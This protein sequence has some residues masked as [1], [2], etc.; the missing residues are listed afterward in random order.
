MSSA[1][2]S[3]PS[4][5][6]GGGSNPLPIFD[7]D[8][9]VRKRKCLVLT[10]K[11]RLI[12]ELAQLFVAR[13]SLRAALVITTVLL[14]GGGCFALAQSVISTVGGG[15]T[16]AI[17][18]SLNACLPIF[19]ARPYGT[20]IY[21]VS[22]GRIYKIDSSGNWTA[23]AGTGEAGFS[24]DG[25]P[26]LSAKLGEPRSISLDNNGNI[27]FLDTLNIRVRKVDTSGNISTIAGTG[28]AGYSGDGG[29]AIK[30]QIAGG[31]GP[32]VFA[33]SLGN[34]YIADTAN[35]RVRKI[36][37]SLNI[38]T[39][40]GTGLRG[41][42][43]DNILATSAQLNGPLDVFVDGSG[44][45]F[46]GEAARVR[47]IDA[48]TKIIST[49]AGTGATG[50]NGD[51]I[52]ATTAELFQARGVFVDGTGNVFISDAFNNRVRKVSTG[53][54][55]STVAGNGTPYIG[56]D[57]GPAVNAAVSSPY[58]AILD[59]S[60]NL[61]ITEFFYGVRKV[62]A[63]TQQ[64]S[65]LIVNSAL[66]FTGV[67]GPAVSAQLYSPGGAVQD[68]AGNIFFA[69]QTNQVVQE[70]VKSEGTLV[71]VAGNGTSG[72]SGDTG[73]AITAQLSVPTAVAL[74]TNGDIFIADSGNNVIRRVNAATQKIT[75]VAGNGTQG[76][77]G[78]GPAT[79]SELYNP[80]G[81]FV[82][83]S[84]N[85]FI[86]DL[87]NAL[88]RRVDAV[89][90]DLSTVA[91]N[92]PNSGYGGNGGA[93]TSAILNSPNG[94]FVDGSGNL[95]IADAGNNI[96]QRVDAI[97]KNISTV[98]G[99][100]LE[101]PGF[102]G[103]GGPATSAQLN[104]PWAIWGDS[105]GNLFIADLINNRIREFTVGG[106]IQTVAGSGIQGFSG[107]GG[108]PVSA[109]LSDPNSVFVGPND[110]LVIVDSSN[111]HIRTVELGQTISFG[112][113]A[114]QYYVNPPFAISATASSGLP[115]I[116]NSQ[117]SSTCA[118]SGGTVT[119]LAVGTCTIQATQPGNTQYAAAPPIEQSF[120]VTQQNQ[121]V[122]GLPAVSG[123]GN[124][125][126]FGCPNQFNLTEFQQV[127]SSTTFPGPVT[128]NQITFFNTQGVQ[129]APITPANYQ[130]T[131]STTSEAI[132]GLDASN[133]ANN[134]GPDNQIF[135]SG[136]LSGPLAAQELTINGTPFAYDPSNGNLLLMIFISGASPDT[137]LA[138]DAAGIIPPVTERVYAPN[139][140]G[141]GGRSPGLVTQFSTTASAPQGPVLAFFPSS[142]TFSNL[143]LLA[144][145]PSYAVTLT[146]AGT[147]TL[148]IT[149]ISTTGDF[150]SPSNS[151]GGSISAG[152]SCTINVTFTPTALGLRT[153]SLLISDNA[154][155][156]PQ[157]VM[158]TSAV[159]IDTDGDGI[160][161]D[162]ETNG[163]TING[164]FL[165]LPAMGA[166][167]RHKDVFVQTDYMVLLPDC[168][169]NPCVPGHS[170]QLQADAMNTLIA[171]YAKAPVNNPDGTTGITL[172]ID[173]GPSCIMNPLTGATWGNRSLANSVP[174]LDPVTGDV[175][176][177]GA[178]G[179]SG[180]DWS[181]FNLIK[182]ANL[183]PT[184]A[185]VFHYGVF[186]HNLDPAEGGTS[187]LSRDNPASDFVVSLGS[188]TGGVGSTGEQ[189]GTTMHELGH[190]LGLTHGGAAQPDLSYKPNFTSVMNYLFQTRG[191][192]FDG[193]EGNF[194]YSRFALPTLNE[195]N[196]NEQLGLDGGA[197]FAGYGTAYFCNGVSNTTS[198]DK[199]V[200]N[201]NLPIDWNCD[202]SIESSVA[203][204]IYG[205]L[206]AIPLQKLTGFDDWMNLVFTGG[207][208]G[209]A[210]APPP[211]PAQT[212]A[213]ELNSAQDA[214]LTTIHGVGVVGPGNTSLPPGGNTTLIFT[215]SNK[216]SVSDTFRITVSST[217]AWANIGAVPTTLALA[218][219]ASGQISISVNVPLSGSAGLMDQ[220]VVKATS[221]ANPLVMDSAVANVTA[222]SADMAIAVTT[223]SPSLLVGQALTY[224]LRV[225]NNG[226]N[227]APSTTVTDVLPST[228]AFLSSSAS[229]GGCLGTGTL[230]CTLGPL[231]VGLS[232]TI[233]ITVI[234]QSPGTTVNQAKA[235]SSISDS[236]L[237]NNSVTTTTLV[238]SPTLSARIVSQSKSGNSVT[239]G[240]QLTNVG[241]ATAQDTFIRQIAV[242]GLG[243]AGT[244]TY[245]GPTLPITIGS[246]GVGQ[247]T[248]ATL[249]ITVPSTVAKLSL[250]EQGSVQDP[251]GNSYSFSLAQVVFP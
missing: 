117:T 130:F 193:L 112:T 111:A 23:V 184:R 146:N 66:G 6:I 46:I 235:A 148:A 180:Y 201:A 251:A 30:A 38:N 32:G 229:S 72:Y 25:G 223:S 118:V 162:W 234:P 108:P 9:V 102:S 96:I 244:V 114:N 80:S 171:A 24:G 175:N 11:R 120:Q 121:I 115:V 214:I 154:S 41:Y 106:N 58:H 92:Y 160:P 57:G 70:I 82:D 137:G 45:I 40:A 225:T 181:S 210:G 189:A 186:A 99:N 150:A 81:L 211:L 182:A 88:V 69:D 29:P 177:L 49:I 77:N 179:S 197:S 33:D 228:V 250:T 3:P 68:G 233:N 195:A 147:T 27:Y 59:A 104:S 163:V 236:Q 56:G 39:V 190:N 62:N 245:V 166:N 164:V 144:T 209:Q 60:G 207:S 85:I 95:F 131:L 13:F 17:G 65:S 194:D 107:D 159:Y 156:S 165:D 158:L 15:A 105:A 240:L 42:N 63:A 239:V 238:Q 198:A 100:Y 119:L 2:S 152:S 16:A 125:V 83:G 74:D 126:P 18:P 47:R 79:S 192:E 204:H 176:H 140:A 132:G 136:Q 161:D 205:E 51:G 206:P 93:A 218:P 196:L 222:A 48:V 84:G 86:A 50:Y 128:I 110:S 216:G 174:H 37:S 167:P 199:I 213:Q 1:E 242:R 169:V 178:L 237:K 232:S 247:S 212:P 227:A 76:Y 28:V 90:K 97:T 215:V 185:S 246:L 8:F 21:V 217:Q 139:G 224:T 134:I 34:V 151:C 230:V 43:G 109:E 53:G 200:T 5:N 89:T 203:T 145:S 64:I 135:F 71:T 35:Q 67:G 12:I 26:A 243:G 155:N 173:C 133:L 103:D 208:I 157:S 61:I 241:T 220:V 73:P 149:K 122:S 249:T 123:T 14:F 116:F 98:A 226:P 7:G 54:I 36:D 127:Y 168:S 219:K 129:G 188:F 75:T 31:S 231:G 101:G 141:P 4:P 55:I 248:T 221:E 183:S 172:H 91:G 202:G 142:I 22:C 138:L 187:G 94:V 78:D 10:G 44:N 191:L 170:H 124:C 143:P 113:L 20:Y 19:S 153:G 52:A 87:Y